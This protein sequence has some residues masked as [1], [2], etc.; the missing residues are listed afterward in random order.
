[1]RIN[2]FIYFKLTSYRTCSYSRDQNV[3]VS[4]FVISPSKNSGHSAKI[5]YIVS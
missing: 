3:F 4:C 1:M 2:V 5:W